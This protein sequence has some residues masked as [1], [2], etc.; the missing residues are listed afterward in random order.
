MSITFS[1]RF[2]YVAEGNDCVFHLYQNWYLEFIEINNCA[3]A[4][5]RS[6]LIVVI[7]KN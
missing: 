6:Q 5:I 3:L 7:K 4:L 2:G 1:F